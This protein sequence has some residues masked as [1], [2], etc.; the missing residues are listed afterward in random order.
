MFD[1]ARFWI[2]SK[3]NLQAVAANG[4]LSNDQGSYEHTN[5]LNFAN[6]G[7]DEISIL[8]YKPENVTGY[9]IT[10]KNGGVVMKT[11]LMDGFVHLIIFQITLFVL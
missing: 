1:R 8:V 9:N 3:N 7:T 11:F 5:L 4:L 6:T 10:A 2:P